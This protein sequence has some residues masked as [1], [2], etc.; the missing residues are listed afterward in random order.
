[1]ASLSWFLPG[2]LPNSQVS[3]MQTTS[4]FVYL[5]TALNSDNLPL[6]DWALTFIIVRVFYE[7]GG[8]E[9]VSENMA[10]RL[11]D[12]RELLF[13]NSIFLVCWL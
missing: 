10:S 11:R 8:E 4:G 3:V 12:S 1:M 9:E 5:K 2:F 6:I 7:G 13:S